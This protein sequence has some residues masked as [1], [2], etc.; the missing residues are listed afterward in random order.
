MTAIFTRSLHWGPTI[1]L[2]CC[3]PEF[4]C[5][6][7]IA[8]SFGWSVALAFAAVNAF[9][10]FLFGR[11]LSGSQHD[12]KTVL[13][14]AARRYLGLFI[15]GQ[16]CAIAVTIFGF[17]AYL[18]TPMFGGSAA[19]GA[20]LLVLA[21]CS[22]GH[23]ANLSTLKYL[24]FMY[25][26]VGMAAAVIAL[27]ALGGRSAAAA[28]PPFSSNSRLFGLLAPVLIGSLLGPWTDIRQWRRIA[29]IR[30][31]EGSATLAYG[32]G[33]ILLFVLL[34]L[35]GLLARSVV[36][37]PIS[38]PGSSGVDSAVI[39]T[40]IA[41]DGQSLVGA[42]FFVWVAVS[43]ISTF[44]SSYEAM[45]ELMTSAA[46]RSASALMALIP[47]WI[48]SSPISIIF[49]GGCVAAAAFRAELPLVYVFAPFF[50]F[51]AGSAASLAAE[52]IGGGRSY[53]S[54]LSYMIGSAALLI[55]ISGYASSTP[56]LLALAPLIALI[57]AAP[58]VVALLGWR[59]GAGSVA[60]AI[61]RGPDAPPV[62][63]TVTVANQD[64]SASFGFDGQWFVLHMIPTYDD[65]NSVGNI[66]FL[67][68]LRWVGKA[69][70]LFFNAC[71][72][73]FDLNR[74]NFYVLTHSIRHNFRREAREFEPIA[75]RLRIAGYNRKFVRL[76]HEIHSE[77]RGFLGRGEQTLMFVD[78]ENFHPLD[79]PRSIVEGF[80]PY[81]P[82]GSSLAVDKTSER[83]TYFD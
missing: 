65:T 28:I 61:P 60:T 77:S 31:E 7:Q 56:A 46:A 62:S 20:G 18:W 72:P 6:T 80:L 75:V 53:D 17:V 47:N 44:D 27:G 68:Y 23:S 16:L 82:K 50:T 13:I 58:S 2:C 63:A 55:F 71:M 38:T 83:A 30:N 57:G 34:T 74:T 29:Q 3:G 59:F 51:F 32:A 10:L 49:A 15:L 9:S 54:V 11:L 1:A 69:R 64:A 24:H 12:D 25:I 37:I 70:E 39:A 43:V 78:T 52:T 22:V 5:A 42:A 33:S 36:T 79:I 67:N 19:I 8:L 45:R 14:S 21:G 40:I 48:V 73:N 35:T 66:Y 4:F 76:V 81:A 41:R 26:A